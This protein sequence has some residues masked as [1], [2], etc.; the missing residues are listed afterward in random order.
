[1]EKVILDLIQ[2]ELNKFTENQIYTLISF[3]IIFLLIQFFIQNYWIKTKLSKFNSSL[4]KAE[5]KFTKHH[6]NQVETY[7]KFYELLYDF[8][9]DL[10]SILIQ[11]ENKNQ[12]NEFKLKI[13]NWLNTNNKT[14]I[15]Y[16]KNRILF[17]KEICVKIDKSIVYFRDFTQQII[18]NNREI[19]EFEDYFRGDFRYMYNDEFDETEQILKRINKIKQLPEFENAQKSL[20]ELISKIENEYRNMTK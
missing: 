17:T 2:D 12:H 16:S 7:K 3:G 11:Q 20:Q 18:K 19:R 10:T 15:F 4:K 9:F 6:T 5:I 13:E 1:M 14:I 8:K